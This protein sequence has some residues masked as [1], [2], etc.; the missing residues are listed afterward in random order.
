[1][2]RGLRDRGP[3]RRQRMGSID[4][5]LRARGRGLAGFERIDELAG[6]DHGI[7]HRG[8]NRRRALQC[9][10]DDPVEQV[11]DGPRELADVGGADHAAAALERVE[12][13]AHTGQGIGLERILFP[14]REQLA[15]ACHLF[16][17]FLYI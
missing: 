3:V 4:D 12:R 16:P 10:L 7:A 5:V 6:H 9:V 2:G 11:L 14:G 8:E 1:M 17:R 15:N 13:A